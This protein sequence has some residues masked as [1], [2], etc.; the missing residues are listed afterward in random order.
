[1][2]R[3]IMV[4]WLV[5]AGCAGN[6]RHAR[7]TA[8]YGFQAGSDFVWVR[9]PWSAI[10]PST[11]I[12]EVIDQLCPAVMGLP[13]ATQ[14]DYGQE[15]CGALY[16][17]GDGRY[18]ASMPSPLGDLQLVG[19]TRR[20]SCHAPS[21]VKDARGR[22]SPIADF[23]SHPW[24]PSAMSDRDRRIS[25]QVWLIRIQFDSAC[26]IQKLIPY[27]NDNRPGEVYERRGKQWKRVGII[28]L[29]D[30]ATGLV[31]SVDDDE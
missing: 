7:E 23:H 4:A 27:A 21:L 3:L 17:L 9:G 5:W 25:T 12:D 28:K 8:D 14:R 2:R 6:A 22:T 29:E 19:A 13:A 20:K 18:F 1:M 30:K 10:T 26:T 16:S 11:D 15:Y 31:T 24:S